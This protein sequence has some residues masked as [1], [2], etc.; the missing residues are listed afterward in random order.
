MKWTEH[1]V[2]NFEYASKLK[3]NTHQNSFDFQPVKRVE[4]FP[5][6]KIQKDKNTFA[7]INMLLILTYLT[8]IQY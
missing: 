4:K 7:K 3:M 8:Y 2:V 6:S 1:V 5:L